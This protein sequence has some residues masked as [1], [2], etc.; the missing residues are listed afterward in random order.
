MRPHPEL[1]DINS[2]NII[3]PSAMQE[4][5]STI[6]SKTRLASSGHG[7]LEATHGRGTTATAEDARL[8]AGKLLTAMGTVAIRREDGERIVDDAHSRS[9]LEVMNGD[10]KIAEGIYGRKLEEEKSL[11]TCKKKDDPLIAANPDRKVTATKNDPNNS[12]SMRWK[13]NE[14]QH[15][16]D[17]QPGYRRTSTP[18]EEHIS[19]WD[20]YTDTDMTKMVAKLRRSVEQPAHVE[21]HLKAL[22]IPHQTTE[23]DGR[24]GVRAIA[25]TA[26]T[27]ERTAMGR[28]LEV[29]RLLEGLQTA[30]ARVAYEVYL[31]S[32]EEL[33]A[34]VA[35]KIGISGMEQQQRDNRMA[36]WYQQHKY[37]NFGESVGYDQ[38]TDELILLGLSWLL[39]IRIV[40]HQVEEMSIRPAVSITL[41]DLPVDFEQ[42]KVSIMWHIRKSRIGSHYDGMYKE[43]GTR[44]AR[45]VQVQ[46][47]G[48]WEATVQTTILEV[49]DRL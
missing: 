3:T 21:H 42:T 5:G 29:L 35:E 11:D 16:A 43:E 1:A 2:S 13:G 20:P 30:A 6:M 26:L 9:R 39:D 7:D 46:T 24:C 28:D 4:L 38:W 14:M 15:G 31:L 10:G 23:A 37:E 27:D 44:K 25:L 12:A 22:D 48:E 47:A 40:Y 45:Q 17:S 33:R 36:R 34:Q 19:R 32:G 18:M 41:P 8:Q 49:V